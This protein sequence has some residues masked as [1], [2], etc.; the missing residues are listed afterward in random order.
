M[1]I[2]DLVS[3]ASYERVALR[4]PDG[5]WKLHRGQP[6]EK[7]GM[8]VEHN[9]VMSELPYRLQSQLDREAFRVRTNSARLRVN[10]QNDYI[11]DVAVIPTAAVRSLQDRLGRLDLYIDPIPLVVEIWLPSTGGYDIGENLAGYQERGDEKI[12]RIHPYE[13]TLIVWRRQADGSDTETVYD[14]GTVE[15]VA[16]PGVRLDLDALLTG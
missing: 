13:K 3:P 15:P 2:A 4:D 16:L 11:P 6:R 7:P 5:R 9:E 10:E 1:A 8:S 14:G 12:W